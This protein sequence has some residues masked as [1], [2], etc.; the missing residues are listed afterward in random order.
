MAGAFAMGFDS[1]IA[2]TLNIIPQYS[3]QIL[4][5]IEANKLEEAREVQNRLSEA[6]SIITKNGKS[7]LL[8]IL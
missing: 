4:E 6:C 7:N 3:I 2:T 5:A 8:G 1:A